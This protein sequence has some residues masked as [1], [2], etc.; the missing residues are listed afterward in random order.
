M[1]DYTVRFPACA[2]QESNKL[3]LITPQ[4]KRNLVCSQRL[5][6]FKHNRI[7]GRVLVKQSEFRSMSD[8]TTERMLAKL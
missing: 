5:G 2:M 6:R 3:I 4:G 1:D 7:L 8:R